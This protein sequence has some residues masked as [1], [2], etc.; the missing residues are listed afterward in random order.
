VRSQ[1]FDNSIEETTAM[2][3]RANLVI[4]NQ[5]GYDLYYNHWC[6]NTLPR[7]FFWGPEHAVS[8]IEAQTKVDHTGWLND[9]WAEGGA[10]V[11]REKRLLLLFGGEDELYDI[12][13][14]RILLK[15]MQRVWGDWELRWANEGIADIAEYA[16]VSKEVVLSGKNDDLAGG[17]L[18]S[19]EEMRWIDSIISIAFADGKTLIFP[20]YGDIEGVLLYGPKL[21]ENCDRS[22]GYTEFRVGDWTQNFPSSGFHLD[23]ATKQIDIW[24]AEPLPTIVERMKKVWNGWEIREHYDQYEVQLEKLC[25]RLHFQTVDRKKILEEITASLLRAPANPVNAMSSLVKR[26][27]EDGKEVEVSAYAL[28]HEDVHLPED[29]RRSIVEYASQ[30]LESEGDGHE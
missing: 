20:Q 22:I 7:D 16:G 15:L 6:A 9:I 8:F 21:L 17:G 4:M 23:A 5:D 27:Q 11:D 1:S 26:L 30:G 12:P 24:H 28:M 3:Q 18:T 10:V 29:I 19:P 2:G 25:G 13:R 14:R